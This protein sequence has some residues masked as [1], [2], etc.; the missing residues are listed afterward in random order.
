[1]RK[2]NSIARY[3]KNYLLSKGIHIEKCTPKDSIIDLIKSLQPYQTDKE[4]IR[5]GNK[6]DGGYLVPNDLVG[7]RACF[8][9]G[10][11]A[12]CSFEENCLKYGMKVFLAD[13]SVDGPPIRNE[14]FNFIK[15][16]VGPITTND[17]ITMND[18]INTNI[19]ENSADLLLQMDIE[20]DEYY[21]IINMT[22]TLLKRFRI[23][24]IEFHELHQL[25]NKAFFNMANIV[26]K[27]ILNHHVCVHIHPNNYFK[28]MNICGIEIPR[29]AEFTFLRKDR[30]VNMRPATIFPHPLDVDCLNKQSVKLPN[31]WYRNSKQINE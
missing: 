3:L 30:I 29:L 31:S 12:L 24:I 10:V 11:G 4:L 25:A 8:S 2:I 17:H 22:E 16:F 9:P 14:E 7:I 28:I 23:I 19:Q 13:N 6:G 18:W 21:S 15:K 1:M 5:L 20:G 27:K 26:F